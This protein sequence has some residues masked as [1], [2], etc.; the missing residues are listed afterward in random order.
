MPRIAY[1]EWTPSPATQVV[2]AQADAICSSYQ[3]QGYDL[4]LRQLY[5]QF[6]S[7]GLIPNKDTAYKR[8]GSIVNQAR[9]AGLLDWDYITDRTRELVDLPHWDD[10]ADVIRS[11][12]RGYHEA[13]WA[14][15]DRRVEVW[16][17]KDALVGVIE[18][19]CQTWDVPFFSCRGYTSQSE[20]WVAARRLEGYLD[21]GAS[22][23]VILHLGDHDPSG[24]DMTRDIEDRLRLFLGGDGYDEDALRIERLALNRDQVDRYSPPPN[25]TKL[26]DSRAGPYLARHGRSSWE[27]DALE[28]TVIGALI[29]AAIQE[30]VDEELYGEKLAAQEEARKVLTLASSRWRDVAAFLEQA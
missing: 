15:Q 6:V 10:P 22:E 13:L 14:G 28:P 25:P 1:I 17:E 5:Y 21:D 12:A 7:R 26:T 9:L 4:T 2:I 29:T 19:P 30:E 20:V 11:A 3:A 18:A 24:L 27:L 8:L 23:V 16:I